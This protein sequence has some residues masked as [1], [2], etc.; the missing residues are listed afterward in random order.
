MDVFAHPEFDHHEQVVFAHDRGSGLRAIIAV[1]DTTLGPALGGCRMWPY[2]DETEA[3]TDVLRLSRGM[4]R[5]SAAAGL[6]LGGGKAVIIG[7]PHTERTPALMQAMGRAIERLNG[8]Y[9]TA[10]DSGIGVDD[11]AALSTVTRHVV[12]IAA[13]QRDDGRAHDGDPSPATALG[14]YL[15]LHAAVRAA[16]GRESLDGLT[17]AIQGTGSVGAHLARRLA[18]DGVRLV[19]ADI[20]RGTAEALADEL[21]AAVTD[22]DAITDVPCDV[23]SPCA[24]GATLNPA[25]RGRLRCRIVAGAANNQLATPADGAALWRAG[26]LYAPDFVINAGGIIDVG[27]EYYGYDPADVRRRIEAIGTSLDTVFERAYRTGEPPEVIAERL[28]DERLAAARR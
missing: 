16:L 25:T 6:A 24:L 14:V 7:D 1:H 9:V 5:K 12:G 18:A 11:L 28:A 10:E 20:H 27:S 8:L 15:G 26:I 23:F 21:G 4:T 19:L 13:K 17:V 2:A 3:L 22:A